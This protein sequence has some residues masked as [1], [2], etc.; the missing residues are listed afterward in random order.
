MGLKRKYVSV[1][2]N[3][4]KSGIVCG[5]RTSDETCN[6]EYARKG[7]CSRKCFKLDVLIIKINTTISPLPSGFIVHF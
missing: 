5:G 4:T 6:V 7:K 1:A 3:A 2:G